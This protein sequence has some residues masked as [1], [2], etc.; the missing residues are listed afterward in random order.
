MNI[1]ISPKSAAIATL[2][3]AGAT[4]IALGPL[5]P[6]A[7]PVAETSPSLTDI[8]ADLDTIILN[9]TGGIDTSGPFE[10]FRTPAIGNFQR[11]LS[12]SLIAEGRVYVHSI[13]HTYGILAVFDGPGSIDVNG[14]GVSGTWIAR[15]FHGFNSSGGS[16]QYTAVTTPVEQVVENGLHAAWRETATEGF[17]TITYKRLTEGASE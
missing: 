16:A 17:I 3:A 9:Q 11:N 12:G 5:N 4:A 2:I 13:T 10:S 15:S 6:P 14:R 7:G 1:H 8:A